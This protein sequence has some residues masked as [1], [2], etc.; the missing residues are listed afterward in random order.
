MNQKLIA[1]VILIFIAIN[2]IVYKVTDINT[3]NKI[4]IALK[5][6]LKNLKTHYDMLLYNQNLTAKTLYD[7]TI[8]TKDFLKVFEEAKTASKEHRVVLRKTMNNILYHKYKRAKTKGVLQYHFVFP[9]N[10]V[11]LRMHKP[12]KYGDDL[13]NIREDFKYVNKTKQAIRAFTQ[14]RTAHGFRNT[15]P[16]FSNDGKY[17]GAMEISFS[18]DVFQNYLTNISNIHTHFIVDKN[19]FNSK[20]WSR[21]DMVVKYVQSFEHKDF[22]QS[23]TTYDNEKKY[24]DYEKINIKKISEII[25]KKILIGENF[26]TYFKDKSDLQIVSFLAI[27]NMNKK[28]VAWLVS[29]TKSDLIKYSLK[30]KFY[31]TILTFIFTSIILYF[32]LKQITTQH[33]KTK[34]HTSKEI[35][36]K[37]IFIPILLI[38]LVISII[39]YLNIQS[40]NN[41]KH[42][43]IE[44]TTKDFIS[45][46]KQIVHHDV[47]R[48]INDIDYQRKNSYKKFKN[49][50]YTK[51]ENIIIALQSDYEFNKDIKL[52]EEIKKELLN[53]VK[54][55]NKIE[56]NRQFFVLDIDTGKALVHN[57]KCEGKIIKEKRYSNGTYVF[58]SKVDILKTKESAYQTLYIGRQSQINQ[59]FEKLVYFRKFK[60]YNWIIGTAGFLV[61]EEIKLQKEIQS[62]YNNIQKGMSNYLFVSKLNNID[63]GKDFATIL[64]MP[65]KPKVINKTISDD[66][67]DAKGIYHRK[68]Y[69][70]ALKQN[71][72]AYTEYWY[73]NPNTN[74]QDKK[75]SYFY[76]YKPW[77]WIVGEGFYF[78]KLES[79]INQKEILIKKQ[80]DKEILNNFLIAISFILLSSVIFYFFSKNIIFIIN[81]HIEKLQE[82]DSIL[83]QQSKLAAMGEMIGNI[84]HQW[85][86]PLNAL[87]LTIQK[88]QMFHNEDMLTGDALNKSVNKSKIL[89]NKMSTTIDD[90]RNFFKTDKVK[91]QFNIKDSINAVLNLLESSLKNNNIDIDTINIQNDIEFI[92]YKNELE[93]VLLNIIN[94]AKDA[95]IE[96]NIQ[97]PNIKISINVNHSNIYI[98]ILDNA[99][100]I[101]E[102]IIDKIFEPYFTTKEQ[103]KGTGIG[104][105]M[106]NMIIE[107]NMNGKLSV[108]NKSNGA[109]FTIVLNKEIDI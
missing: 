42:N 11:F 79:A 95:L 94:N 5:N 74:M 39:T 10:K 3:Q 59:K 81:Q 109:C 67:V 58:Q 46:N 37:L 61:D 78:N 99:G 38:V 57:E 80:L 22:M 107:T 100:G 55:Q 69:L 91:Q 20:T 65:N 48:F 30:N 62:K 102:N 60:Q 44:S 68:E 35:Y 101:S 31:T 96:N 9:D 50:L 84:A 53:I 40:W 43:A 2:G 89:I 33:K 7:S 105:Y 8:R 51:V 93:Q 108:K 4:D 77:N 19:I 86:Q 32:I 13:T 90:F 47:S 45:K 6:D 104:L 18:S 25:N 72:E 98:E 34:E 26:S 82:K 92:G 29:Y 1:L 83:V 64:V 24:I 54:S 27:K 70:K 97:K 85:R 56:N 28:S 63:G 106:S 21:N 87:G 23:V 75:L 15:F 66:R 17:L 41:H 88:I 71:G 52:D 16:V 103:G 76:L 36:Y 12:S 14:G 73:Q 49:D